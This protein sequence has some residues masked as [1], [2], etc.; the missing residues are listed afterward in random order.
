MQNGRLRRLSPDEAER[1]MGFDAGYTNVAG[2]VNTTRYRAV[3]NSWAVPVVSWIGKRLM[4][5]GERLFTEELAPGTCVQMPGSVYRNTF[6]IAVNCSALPENCAFGSMRDIVRPVDDERLFLSPASCAG[7][8]RRAQERHVKTIQGWRIFWNGKEKTA[9]GERNICERASAKIGRGLL[10]SQVKSVHGCP[11]SN[12]NVL[13]YVHYH[14]VAELF[15][16]L[17]GTGMN[18]I[19]VRIPHESGALSGMQFS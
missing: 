11:D 3:G 13:Q 7:I 16:C 18:D 12:G 6:G 4:T 1:L 9:A 19:G 14:R 8:M 5:G 10:F 2:A 17:P 15:V